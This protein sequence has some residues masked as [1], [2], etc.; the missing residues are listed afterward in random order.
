MRSRLRPAMPCRST[1]RF[2]LPSRMKVRDKGPKDQPWIEALLN[3]RWGG[4]GKVIV[5]GEVFDARCLPGLIAGQRVG[6]ATFQIR[7]VKHMP[8]PSPVTLVALTAGQG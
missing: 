5:H 3:E 2:A 1:A 8:I 4:G 6:L 7:R